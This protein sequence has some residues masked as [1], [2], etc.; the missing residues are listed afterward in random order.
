MRRLKLTEWYIYLDGQHY[1]I[2]VVLDSSRKATDV[3][4]NNVFS[5]LRAIAAPL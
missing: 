1:F 2:R 5:Q 4:E 3:K